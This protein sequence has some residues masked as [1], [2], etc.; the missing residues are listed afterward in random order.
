MTNETEKA[1][2]TDDCSFLAA[3]GEDGI[4]K[5]VADFYRMMDTET[6]AE[7]I[8]TMHPADL[9]LS[10]DKLF[11][12][13]C[14]WMGG[15]KLYAEKYGSIIIPHAHVDYDIG[16]AEKDAWLGCMKLALD[17]QPYDDDFKAYLLRELEVPANNIVSLCEAMKQHS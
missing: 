3:G 13:L 9:D 1:Y 16:I 7:D 17:L 5:L 6:M 14:G 10:E 12:F 8:R 4:K 15:P 2:G 11:C